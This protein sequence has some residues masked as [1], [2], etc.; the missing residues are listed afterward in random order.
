[1]WNSP[2]P[3]K[4]SLRTVG[5]QPVE[6]D[7]PQG[8]PA[9]QE[10]L[11]GVPED[12]HPLLRN[13]LEAWDR[14]VEAKL[15]GVRQEYEAYQPLV[16]NEV[17]FEAVEQALWLAQQLEQNPDAVVQQAIDAFG[18]DFVAKAAAAANEEDDN[19]MPFGD[20]FE[21]LEDHPAFK[22][23]QQKAEEAHQAVQAQRE[24]EEEP[25]R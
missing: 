14:G 12:L 20:D 8:H 1:V 25:K 21:G 9:W 2:K 23:M 4:E 13:K 3:R 16:E 15:Q 24:A 5:Q 7:P 22:E 6:N 19:D 10:I 11:N 18:L 17:P